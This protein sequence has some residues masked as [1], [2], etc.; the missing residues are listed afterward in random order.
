MITLYGSDICGSLRN[1][2]GEQQILVQ[3]A[4]SGA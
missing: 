2:L 4:P 3:V 1:N